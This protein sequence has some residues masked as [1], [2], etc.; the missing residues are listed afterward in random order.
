MS[1]AST[2]FATSL[3]SLKPEDLALL[4]AIERAEFDRLLNRPRNLAD[5]KLPLPVLFTLLEAV[6]EKKAAM[7]LEAGAPEPKFTISE[8]N[9][10]PETKARF[11]QA[12]QTGSWSD[13][14]E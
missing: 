3:A 2:D 5:L 9:V 1:N 10:S 14:G 4:S 7:S 6:R 12:C 11:L 8:L 13:D